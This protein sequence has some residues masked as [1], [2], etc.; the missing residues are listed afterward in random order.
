MQT[1][2]TFWQTFVGVIIQPFST[3]QRLQNDNRAALKGLLALLLVLATYT[4]ILV[5]FIVHD[6][7]AMAPSILPI[8]VEDLYRYQVWY[9]G[10]LFIVA[11]LILA[12]ILMWLGRVKGQTAS[13]AVTF[14]Q[15]SFATTVPFALTTMA[16]ELVIAILVA[17]R[18]CQPQ[19]VLGWLAG[20]GA[21]FANVYQFAGVLWIIGLLAITAKLSVGVRWWVGIILG[22]VLAIIY[23]VPIGLFIR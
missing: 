5:I 1:R 23:G 11:T 8:A 7:P 14:A 9:Q 19:E 22:V 20:S 17:A 18:V 10:P 15:V 12:G 3:F 4:L 16:V 6:Y 13:F 2:L 21:L